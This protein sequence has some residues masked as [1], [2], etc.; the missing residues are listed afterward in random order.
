MQEKFMDK[1]VNVIIDEDY[2]VHTSGH[3]TQHDLKMMYEILKPKIVLPVHGDK[4]FIRAHK[5]F[6][7]EC[8]MATLS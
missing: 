3:P 2:L 6:A 4:R 8:G 7:K 5:K 1:G